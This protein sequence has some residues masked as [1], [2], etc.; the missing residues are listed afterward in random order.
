VEAK[1][2]LETIRK[3][4][5]STVNFQGNDILYP[6]QLLIAKFEDTNT[7]PLSTSNHTR[8]LEE[9]LSLKQNTSKMV[10]TLRDY[11][12]RKT[13]DPQDHVKIGKFA[14]KQIAEARRL[15]LELQRNK[16]ESFTSKRGQVDQVAELNRWLARLEEALTQLKRDP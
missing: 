13:L 5:F 9:I 8:S 1:A 3:K 15:A 4:D 2:L 14:R 16:I 11:F 10:Q 7:G 6:L 12:N